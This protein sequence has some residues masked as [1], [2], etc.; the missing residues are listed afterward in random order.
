[1]NEKGT[2]EK[3]KEAFLHIVSFWPF[4]LSHHPECRNFSNHTI[5]LGKIRFCIG[6][7]IGY[8]TAILGIFLLP[9]LNI[10]HFIP[11]DLYLLIAICLLSTFILSILNLTKN[12]GIKILQKFLI[13]LGSSFLFWYIMTRPNSRLV[14]IFI[15]N[16]AFGVILGVLNLYHVLGF[17]LTCYKCETPFLWG[18]CGGFNIIVKNFEKHRLNNFFVSFEEFS[19]NLVERKEKKKKSD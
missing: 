10:S 1:M 4:A 15:F 7:F 2:R 17:I 16:I 19:K 14:N 5:H 6:C 12:K 3:I 13:G 9:L 8:P 18:T 11:I